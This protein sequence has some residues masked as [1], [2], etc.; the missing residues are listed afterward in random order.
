MFNAAVKK[1]NYFA[2]PLKWDETLGRDF[3]GYFA[4]SCLGLTEYADLRTIEDIRWPRLKR[5]IQ[6]A[7]SIV[8]VYAAHYGALG[9][10][11]SDIQSKMDLPL[12]P[13]ISKEDFKT[14]AARN[15]DC[16]AQN[17]PESRGWAGTTSGST[18]EPF[19]YFLDSA[20]DVERTALRYR[21]WTRI[22][23]DPFSPKIF[24]APEGARFSMPNLISIHPHFIRARKEEYTRLIKCSRAKVI[25]GFPLLVFDLL[26]MLAEE[27]VP[28]IIFE[29][30]ML[31]G[32]SVAPGIRSF[33][34]DR[35]QCDAFEY[36]GAGETGP[37]AV[38]CELRTALH[39]QEENVIVEI[40]DDNGVPVPD[41]TAGRVLI[42]CLSNEFMPLIR[43]DIGDMGLILP[44]A[45]KCGRKLR[46]M[47]VEGRSGE[48]LFLGPSGE[49]IS[50]SILR[51]ILDP[52]FEYFHRYQVVQQD[53]RTLI[54]NIVPTK[55]WKKDK[56]KEIV[57]KVKESVNYPIRVHINYVKAIPPLSSGKF[58][59]FISDLWS[60]KFPE[61]F[62]T[63]EPLERRYKIISK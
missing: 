10:S 17:V 20:Y 2:D 63:V 36:Y 61:G 44:G 46:R 59:Y 51:G 18:G 29:K 35:F 40:V 48:C 21:N 32:H 37:I 28:N 24:C 11:P 57:E 39:I 26:W 55:F 22:G 25:C 42:T 43:Y 30:A 53:L 3:S 16:R 62:F 60:K 33:L 54:L 34:K 23:I 41:G 1:F 13:P 27:R 5:L 58:Q 50:P 6:H 14:Y 19:R 56:E 9:V 7:Y 31:I 12:L 15:I 52:Y 47:V 49:S 8:P 38:E 45:C 4:R